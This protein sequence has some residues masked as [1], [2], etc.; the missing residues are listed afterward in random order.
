[1]AAA[2]VVCVDL[3]FGFG[4]DL[5]AGVQRQVAVGQQ[6]IARP[7]VGVDVNPAIEDCSAF[8]SADA[9]KLLSTDGVASLVFNDHLLV[10][11]GAVFGYM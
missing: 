4:I 11:M 7:G 9:V 6:C 2:D 5:C 1:M 10:E 8:A 3:K